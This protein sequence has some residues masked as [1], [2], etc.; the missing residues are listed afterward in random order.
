MNCF[1]EKNERIESKTKPTENPTRERFPTKVG[2]VF[3]RLENNY[4]RSSKPKSEEK[5]E[6]QQGTN[7]TGVTT[8]ISK[9]SVA[10]TV[11]NLPKDRNNKNK[12]T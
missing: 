7:L 9:H 6:P 8:H 10:N 3:K 11:V 5:H 1:E 4:K 2:K 12:S